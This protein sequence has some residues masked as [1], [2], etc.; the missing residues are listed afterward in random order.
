MAIFNRSIKPNRDTGFSNT[1]SS[2]AGRFLNRDGKFN[3]KREG[4]PFFKK[5]SFYHQLLDLST[6]QF[7]AVTLVFITVMN[8][9]FTTMYYFI[10]MPHFAGYITNNNWGHV[11]E[12]FY[13]SA[14]TFTTVGY[15]RINPTGDMANIV[16]SVEAVTGFL[17]FAFITGLVY[18]RFSKPKANIT[19]SKHAIVAPYLNIT[20]LMF[21]FAASKDTHILSEVAVKINLG[22]QVIE[23]NKP[24]FKFYDLELERSKI[25]SLPMNFTVVHP[26]DEQ[27]PLWAYSAGDYEKADV[28]LYVVVRAFD[29]IYSSTVQLRTS[30][31]YSEILHNVKFVQMYRESA[32]GLN[33]ILEMQNLSKTIGTQ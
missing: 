3:I 16:A 19:F 14:Q 32:D 10:G 8:I 27:S 7:I 21:R 30:Y 6:F 12:L 29:D 15:G 24:V 25:E 17:S 28:E 33:T 9:G 31:I 13:F 23:D 26:I 2:N 20:G 4:L 22:M 5:V 1:S 18:G 11:K